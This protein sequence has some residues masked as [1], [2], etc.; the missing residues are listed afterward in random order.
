VMPAF[1]GGDLAE[2]LDAVGGGKGLDVQ[3]VQF[4]TGCIV[5]GVSKLHSLGVAYRDLK[6]ENILLSTDGWPVLS[7]FGLVA[8]V[9]PDADGGRAYTVCGTPE[10]MA[11][12]IVEEMGHDSDVDW[13]A[14]GVT[15][16]ELA[17]LNTPFFEEGGDGTEDLFK[18]IRSGKYVES[19]LKQHYSRLEQRTAAI[20]DDLLK[21]DTAVRLG[22]RR[23]G[24]ESV[25]IHPFFWG[26][27][28]EG[29]ESQQTRPPHVLDC[30]KKAAGIT[31][32][33]SKKI[34]FSAPPPKSK[35]ALKESSQ[36]KD[37]ATRALDKMF[38]FAGW[39][40]EM[41]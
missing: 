32:T 19:F 9:D 39:G 11:P 4:Y 29:L 21:A 33:A 3:A 22:A 20:V 8:F 31:D 40:P 15:I 18:Q 25:R 26:M 16:C 6:P 27:S 2:L 17:T 12:E 41:A 34:A 7:D 10:F 13:W 14:L 35:S 5:L 36:K 1:L 23:R 28:W 38:D 24:A 30:E 37:A